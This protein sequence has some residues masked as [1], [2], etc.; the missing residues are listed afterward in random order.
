MTSHFTLHGLRVPI[1]PNAT[2]PK[3]AALYALSGQQFPAPS[4]GP[5]DTY[6]IGFAV[7]DGSS[8][9]HPA[10]SYT[11][12]SSDSEQSLVQTYGQIVVTLNPNVNWSNLTAGTLLRVPASSV[13]VTLDQSTVSNESPSTSL[14]ISCTPSVVPLAGEQP[15]RHSVAAPV[16]WSAA[17]GP[18]PPLTPN[19]ASPPPR[20]SGGSLSLWRL[21]A[22]LVSSLAPGSTPHPYALMTS[23]KSQPVGTDPTEA[24]Y[25]AWATWVPIKIQR[26]PAP[27]GGWLDGTYLVVGADQVD[28]DTLLWLWTALGTGEG[29]NLSLAYAA[30]TRGG[31]L[32]SDTLDQAATAILKTNLSTETHSGAAAAAAV[33]S[34]P[35]SGTPPPAWSDAYAQLAAPTHF[36]QLMWE[37]SVVGTGG[38]Y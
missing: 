38:F 21:P 32:V 23:P 34:R 9:I 7:G 24:S 33:R 2:N 19:R 20:P 36:L 17:A 28:R 35:P 15:V 8:W 11:T 31:G 25:Y 14:T 1:P 3:N 18:V 6:D 30:A 26:V 12:T 13:T 5:S 37:A 22:S 27:D 10:A 16:P 4:L 29:V